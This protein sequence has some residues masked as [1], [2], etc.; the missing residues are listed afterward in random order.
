MHALKKIKEGGCCGCKSLNPT[1][2]IPSIY[3]P[4]W[5]DA[6]GIRHDPCVHDDACS[7]RAYTCAATAP[8]HKISRLPPRVLIRGTAAAGSLVIQSNQVAGRRR[9]AVVVSRS[10]R[11][12]VVL[13]RMCEPGARA[14]A[15]ILEHVTI[16]GMH[17]HDRTPFRRGRWRFCSLL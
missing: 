15:C 17:M 16:R 8:L 12:P 11:V 5:T 1:P 6:R 3:Y 7:R 13:R 10:R 9:V 4:R 2:M 14:R